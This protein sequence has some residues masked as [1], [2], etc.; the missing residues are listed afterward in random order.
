MACVSSKRLSAAGVALLSLIM[1]AG[2][3]TLSDAA[4]LTTVCQANKGSSR[5]YWSWREID[6]RRCFYVGRPGKSK[7][8]LRWESTNNNRPI[9]RRPEVS[10]G[11]AVEE[12]LGLTCCWPD[13]Q[14]LEQEAE[15]IWRRKFTPTQKIQDR[16][17][18]GQ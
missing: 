10:P 11:P 9:A 4:E 14:Q 8:L 2:E 18:N 13:L 6:G 1:L 16:F 15:E 3:E 5:D 17:P 7:T 12:N